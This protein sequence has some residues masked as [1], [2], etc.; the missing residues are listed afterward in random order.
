MKKIDPS[1][2]I[3]DNRVIRGDT[4]DLSRA[5]NSEYS[6]GGTASIFRSVLKASEDNFEPGTHYAKV[7]A[8]VQSSG[9]GKSRMV[10]QLS[11][12]IPAIVYTLRKPLQT[13][14]PPGDPEILQFL[15][16]ST[17]TSSRRGIE[18]AGSVALLSA[19]ILEI[20]KLVDEYTKQ[21]SAASKDRNREDKST[22]DAKD[23]LSPA[24]SFSKH[25]SPRRVRFCQA[26]RALAE[27]VRNDFAQDK[28][29]ARIFVPKVPIT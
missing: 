5:W 3:E 20:K 29:W 10:D 11:K 6:H 15:L 21:N 12:E 14:Y 24:S 7:I 28:D 25:R 16:E 18:H 22:E 26:V 4:E 27:T 1:S 9:V 19:S 17:S 8:I 13:G 2:L 23:R